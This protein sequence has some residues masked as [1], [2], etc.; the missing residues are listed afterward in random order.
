MLPGHEDTVGNL[1]RLL[2]NKRSQSL[3]DSNYLIF[4]KRQ[5]YGDSKKIHG[6]HRLGG[7][8]EQAEHQG[9]LGQ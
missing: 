8:N 3:C 9:F 1:K 2:S 5:N 6:C 7:N 4:E